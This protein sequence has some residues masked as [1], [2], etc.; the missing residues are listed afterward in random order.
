VGALERADEDVARGDL[1]SARRRLASFVASGEYRP[2]VLARVGNL[3][4]TMG[5]PVE[6]GRWYLLS[7]AEGT[8]VEHA[9]RRFVDTCGGNPAQALAT[10]PHFRRRS[11]FA[12]YAG[13]PRA[14]IEQFGL[15][16]PLEVE[17]RLR[18]PPGGPARL[19]QKLAFV[20]CMA[21]ILAFVLVIGVGTITVLRFLDRFVR[22]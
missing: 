18:N 10:L 16:A 1:G 9:V 20:G 5:D 21:A 19:R 6:A 15:S 11:D 12:Q 7:S 22:Q 3:C 13:A 2:D 8:D 4:L 17:A 14:R